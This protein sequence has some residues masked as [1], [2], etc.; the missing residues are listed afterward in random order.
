MPPSK[1]K[2][3]EIAAEA[4][5]TYMPYIRENFHSQWPATSF[6]CYSESLIAQPPAEAKHVRFGKSDQ[7]GQ[8]HMAY[9][10]SFAAFYNRDPVDVALDW[11]PGTVPVIMPANEKRPGGDWEAGVMSPEECLCRRSNLF[12]TMTTPAEGN[13]TPSNYP[14][15]TKAG[16][17]SEKVG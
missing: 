9:R 7:S 15:P 17:F 10:I 2:P 4:K 6:L 3:S 14:L 11:A 1:P 12:G 5:K 8:F 16:I 13:S